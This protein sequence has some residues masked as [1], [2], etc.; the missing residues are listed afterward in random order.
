MTIRT[1]TSPQLA[2]STPKIAVEAIFDEES[3][4]Y[5]N[6]MVRFS[7]RIAMFCRGLPVTEME[8]TILG[9]AMLN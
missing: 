3:D 5:P 4:R 8:V 2:K 1:S 7:M 9:F 6:N